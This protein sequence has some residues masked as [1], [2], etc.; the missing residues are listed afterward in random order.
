M[1]YV[2]ICFVS[3][4]QFTVKCEGFFMCSMYVYTKLQQPL[5]IV[6]DAFNDLNCV[7]ISLY[8]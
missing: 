4:H 7:G 8:F 6:I 5:C 2:H 1:F 3:V